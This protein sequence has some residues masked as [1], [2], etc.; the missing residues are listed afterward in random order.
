MIGLY[1]MTERDRNALSILSR[2]LVEEFS[3]TKMAQK[4]EGIFENLL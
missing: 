4:Y 1:N 3:A 2:T